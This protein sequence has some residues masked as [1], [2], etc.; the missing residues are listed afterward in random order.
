M[1]IFSL[2]DLLFE[3]GTDYFYNSYGWVLISLAMQEVSGIPF[4]DYVH[5]T[6]LKPLE[7]DNTFAPRFVEYTGFEANSES[8][9]KFST[10]PE[11]TTR[12][13]SFYTRNRSG[14][15]KAVPVNNFYKLAGGGYLSTSADIAKLGQAY[16]DNR[17]LNESVLEQFLTSK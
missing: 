12:I 1:E 8:P 5:R 2:D 3:P 13:T 16:L 14:F 4:E 6:V 11:L 7:M 17:V 10:P 15:R 9:T